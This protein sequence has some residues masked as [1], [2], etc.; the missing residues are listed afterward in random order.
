MFDEPTFG[1][2]SRGMLIVAAV[3]VVVAGMKA[4]AGLVVLLLLALF[5]AVITAP[6]F[7]ALR[8]RGL[9]NAIVLLVM[10]TATAVTGFGI[11]VVLTSS[12]QSFS[13]Y[14]PELQKSITTELVQLAAWLTDKG[15]EVQAKELTQWLSPSAVMDYVGNTVKTTTSVMGQSFLIFLV[16]IFMWLEALIL[17]DKIERMVEKRTWQGLTEAVDHVR[18]YVGLKTVMSLLTG[19]LAGAW[20]W[21]MD[22]PY[23]VVWGV[24]AFFLNFVPTIGSIVAA[25]PPFLLALVQQGG[26]DSMILGIGYVVIN[27]GVS[28]GLEPRFMGK[29]L[30]LSPLV[31]VLSMIIWG[32]V[33]GPVGMFLSVP[34]TTAVKIA[35]EANDE[36][37]WIAVL[38][39]GDV[40]EERVTFRT[41]RHRATDADG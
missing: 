25:L 5:L 12:L 27:V 30:G 15:I 10:I 24:A 36:T 37:R 33:L 19:V 18:R 4:A 40:P 9:S 13:T 32:W 3:V 20:C 28:N 8:R 16:I 26:A 11:V 6:I 35:L 29:G 22:I 34:L 17:P 31:V 14:L 38:L 1:P 21:F 39:G 23:A 7:I 41:R 2:V